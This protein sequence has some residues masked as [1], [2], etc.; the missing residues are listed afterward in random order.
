MDFIRKHRT[1]ILFILLISFLYFFTRILLLGNLPIFTDEAI[2]VRWAQIALNDSNWRFISLTDGKQPMFVWVAIVFMKFIQDPLIAGRLVSVASGFFTIAGLWFLTLELF[3]NKKVAFISSLLYIFFPLAVVLDRM[4]LYDSMVA[5]FF[6]WSLYLSILLLRTPKLEIAYT[7]GFVIGGGILTKTANFFSIYLLPF[8]LLFFNFKDKKWK[9][10]IL[11][12][13]L[14]SAFSVAIAYGLYNV[15]RLSPLFQMISAKNAVFVYPISEWLQH[16]FTFFVGNLNGLWSWLYEYLKIP[17][18]VLIIISL[19]NFRDFAKEKLILI[20]YFL[21]PFIALALFGK[22]IFPRFIFFMSIMLIPLAALGLNYLIE[23]LFKKYKTSKQYLTL[24]LLILFLVFPAFISIQFIYDPINSRIAKADNSQY[25]NS[26]A[27]GW[28]VKESIDYFSKAAKKEKI[29]IATE[30]TFG[31]MP[32]ALEMYL[33]DN[34]NITIKGYWPVDNIS[35][36][37]LDR[38]KKMPTYYVFYQKEHD[39]IPPEFP[40]ELIFQVEQGNTGSFYRVYKVIS[41]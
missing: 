2:Y 34:K 22:V 4:A 14:L 32:F 17:Y 35:K 10:K 40:L 7:L 30:G 11:R 37:V 33:V 25:I 28:G 20:I 3:K 15:L 1:H 19:I 27:A 26:W 38:A 36:E 12:F 41:N 23:F 8:F 18:I 16:P 13:A 24:A 9:E 31:L 39:P 21:L 6:V 29:Y 5:A